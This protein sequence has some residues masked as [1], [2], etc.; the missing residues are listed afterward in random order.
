MDDLFFSVRPHW[1][2]FVAALLLIGAEALLPGVFLFWLGLAAVGTGLLAIVW[3]A[4]F[5]AQ[6]FGF[7]FFAVAAIAA[8]RFVAHWRRPTD[9]APFLN[10]RGRALVGRTAILESAIRDGFGTAFID[11]TIWRVRGAD[12]DA[13]DH[14][15][16]IGTDGTTLRVERKT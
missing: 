11:D 14:V 10:D 9:T 3:P 1:L 6:L 8:G 2:W 7:A 5:V 13:G 12:A 16:V 4:S 15:V